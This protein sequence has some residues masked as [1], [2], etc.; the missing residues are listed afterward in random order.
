VTG[1]IVPAGEERMRRTLDA[2]TVVKPTRFAH[3]VLR[4]RDLEASLAWY[5]TVLG[6]EVVH[7][8]GKLVFLTYDDE[9]HRLALA[10]T[11]VA[12]DVPPGA[13]GLDHVAYTLKSL[14]DLLGTYRRLAA[15]G[16]Q[17]AW[18]VNHGFT[19]SLYYQD[20]DGNRVEFQVEHFGTPAELRGYMESE[21]F[22]RD[23]IGTGFDP[24][25]LAARYENGDPIEELMRPGA[26]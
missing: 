5:Q 13:P 11:P 3:F 16:I 23:P 17:P 7:R 1:S 6:M 2:Q 12:A 21:A 15:R 24:E 26:A 8:A 19:T 10:E 25:K 14:G 9:H 20:P 4:V 18:P 22:A